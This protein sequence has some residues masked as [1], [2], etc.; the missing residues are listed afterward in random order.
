MSAAAINACWKLIGVW[1]DRSCPEL[2]RHTHCRNCEVFC[3]AAAALLDR[4]APPGYREEWTARIAQRRQAKLAGTKSI[5]IFR[6]GEE[7]LAL[8]TAVFVEVAGLRPVHSLPHRTDNIVSGLVNIRGELLLCISL[9][10]VLGLETAPVSGLQ[11]HQT[12]FERML[13]ISQKTGRAV[14]PANEVHVGHRYHPDELKPLPAT[15]ALAAAPRACYSI[16]ILS[17]RNHNVGILDE[18]LLFFTLSRNLGA[19]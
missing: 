8:P 6:I 7:W 11:K 17:W 9:G 1:G 12:I 19:A 3:A 18:E 16:G 2:E 15:V 14:F 10:N 4:P 5:V 13:V